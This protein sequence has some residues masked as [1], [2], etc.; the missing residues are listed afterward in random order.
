[1]PNP[2]VTITDEDAVLWTGPFSE[3]FTENSGALSRLD[4]STLLDKRELFVGGGAA[5][6]LRV[7]LEKA[8]H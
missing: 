8:E 3:F 7:A 1:M 6:L 2:T 5:P 4:F